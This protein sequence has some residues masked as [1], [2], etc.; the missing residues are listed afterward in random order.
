MLD[1]FED[2]FTKYEIARI[3]GARSLQ[4]SMDA[5]VLLKIDK[6]ELDGLNF[7]SLKIAERE[8]ESGVLPITVKK[9]MPKK[10]EKTIRKLSEDEVKEKLEKQAEKEKKEI[11]KLEKKK[12]DI[13]QDV[14]KEIKEEGEIMEMAT[15][16]DEVE[17]EEVPEGKEEL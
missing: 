2:N 4:I 6:D 15:P 14:E 9:P 17:G 13:E 5:P 16:E 11:A 12:E 10:S 7:D 8:F 3:L 1:K